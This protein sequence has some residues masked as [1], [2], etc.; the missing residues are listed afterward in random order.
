MTKPPHRNKLP[1][2]GVVF[3]SVFDSDPFRE[4]SHAQRNV[5]VALTLY[6]TNGTGEVFPKQ[7]T[8]AKVTGL[9][10]RAVK[11]ALKRLVELGFI[12]V[13]WEPGGMRRKNIYTLVG[14]L[15]GALQQA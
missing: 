3:A 13:A 12:T 7:A 11:A 5:Y 9:H 4:L 8:I 14:P 2:H 1:R 10:L 6:A 15:D